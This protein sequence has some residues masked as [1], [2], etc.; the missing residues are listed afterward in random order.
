[1]KRNAISENQLTLPF[2]EIRAKSLTYENR[3]RVFWGLVLCALSFVGI[4][5]Y[6]IN[7]TAHHIA[8]RQNLE[9]QL[10]ETRAELG[11]LEFEHIALKNGVT[12]EVAQAHGFG[13]VSKPL[14]VSRKSSSALSFNSR[15]Q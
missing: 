13:E 2:G 1:M 3:E 9:R 5:I 14:Y 15:A 12:I 4:Y 10:S 6:A 11:A 7:A 8:V